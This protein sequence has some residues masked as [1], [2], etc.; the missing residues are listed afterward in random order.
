[1]M[2]RCVVRKPGE[3]CSENPKYVRNMCILGHLRKG[4]G[5]KRESE[6]FHYF[7]QRLTDGTDIEEA[8]AETELMYNDVSVF[9]QDPPKKKYKSFEP[10]TG[11]QTKH[12]WFVYETEIGTC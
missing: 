5:L 9:E 1:M 8:I 2:T 12:L 4:E 10:E 7:L 11:P 3:Y 6:A